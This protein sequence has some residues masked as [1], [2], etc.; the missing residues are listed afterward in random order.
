M[1]F[2]ASLVSGPEVAKPAEA[3][4]SLAG[5]LQASLPVPEVE[6][7]PPEKGFVLSKEPDLEVQISEGPSLQAL[8][9]HLFQGLLGRHQIHFL[10]E[11]GV[12]ELA[13][14]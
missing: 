8:C 6:G 13:G 9:I 1:G 11:F 10:P 7:I 5:L 14:M 12:P 2:G 4:R 3:F